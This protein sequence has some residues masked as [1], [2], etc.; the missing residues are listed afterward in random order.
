VSPAEIVVALALAYLGLGALVATLFSLR[1][2]AGVDHTA[3]GAGWGFR[4]I[5]WPGAVMLWPLVLA[6]VRR[7]SAASEVR[8]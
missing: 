3:R 2:V 1:W 8:P 7:G 5:I 6:W 4:A